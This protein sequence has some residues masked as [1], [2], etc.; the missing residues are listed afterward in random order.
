[1]KLADYYLRALGAPER[2]MKLLSAFL[3]DYP[4]S[5]NVDTARLWFRQALSG[6]RKRQ[7]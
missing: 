4:N 5:V 6:M 7:S 1:L 3:R 2:A